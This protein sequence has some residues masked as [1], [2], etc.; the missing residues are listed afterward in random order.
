[1]KRGQITIFIILGIV[2]L[3]SFGLIFA[4]RNYVFSHTRADYSSTGSRQEAQDFASLCLEHAAGESVRDFGMRGGQVSPP[5]QGNLAGMAVAYGQRYSLNLI[6]TDEYSEEVLANDI[7]ARFLS[8]MNNSKF[9]SGQ[10]PKAEVQIG[11]HDVSIRLNYPIIAKNGESES[12]ISDFSHSEPARLHDTLNSARALV[13]AARGTE[14]YLDMSTMD[15]SCAGIMACH[16]GGLV[17]VYSYDDFSSPPGFM[18]QF[19]TD[20]SIFLGC[21][22]VEAWQ[23]C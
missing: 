9:R 23:E 5:W 8:C 12:R 3:L 16:S 20:D 10:A 22:L 4:I 21:T 7:E 14:S 6:P 13:Y 18:F 11:A 17:R 2:I 15:L 19:Y 1:M